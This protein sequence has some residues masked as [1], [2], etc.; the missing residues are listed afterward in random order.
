MWHRVVQAV[1]SAQ[2]GASPAGR[3]AAPER[4][5]LE[6]RLEASRRLM[7]ALTRVHVELVTGGNHRALFEQL[8]SLMLDETQSEYGFIG[9][10]LRSPEGAP[11]L[12][13]Y[14]ITN[15]AWTDELRAQYA[16]TV[17]RGMEFRNLKTLFGRVM[18]TGEPVLTN[19]PETHPSALGVPSGHPQ[20]N[21]FLGVPFKVHGDV[22]GM[23]GMANRPGGYC[24][25]HIEF[26]QPLLTTC[27][28][29][30]YS[31]RTEQREK[32]RTRELQ[33]KNEALG[34]AIKQLRDTQQ[35]LV[36]Q[37]KLAS[38]GALT[39]GI[40]HELKNP[41]NFINSFAETSEEFTDELARSLLSQ[42]PRLEP[43]VWAGVGTVLEHLQRNM[44]KIRE[45]SHRAT[46]IINGMLMHSWE[47]SGARGPACLNSVLE[48]GVQLGYQGFCNKV[49]D[50]ELDLQTHLDPAVGEIDV[51]V[52]EISR[53]F[54]NVVDNACYALHQKKKALK[55]AF[56][57][58]LEVR[59]RNLGERV[60]I[61]IRDNG[62]GIPGAQLGRVF[63]PFHTTKPAG[64]GAGLGLSLSRDIIVG[65]H[66]GDI[67]VESVEGQFTELIIEFPRQAPERA[68]P[69]SVVV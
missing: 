47:S 39:A 18:T 45:H 24:E 37:E 67:R 5:V 57:P 16:S 23:V 44:S 35:Q 40:A 28:L 13:T 66:Q 34:R 31:W 63:S 17:A 14:A 64:E 52:L 33:Q 54:I 29:L 49:P 46:Q 6:E 60:E 32:E 25:D 53:V 69:I 65:R 50:F 61:R 20:L 43:A 9:E 19:K 48:E 27:G 26:L 15:I 51:M 38:L 62:T 59:T 30:T 3:P 58:R 42:Q 7:D 8:L 55:D 1:E 41:L 36:A 4:S 11:Y 22:V 56:T 68:R 2:D 10:I 21:A 12:R